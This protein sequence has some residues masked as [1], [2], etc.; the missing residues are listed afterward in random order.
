MASRVG[1]LLITF[2]PGL[3]IGFCVPSCSD[4]T[5]SL[6]AAHCAVC[7]LTNGGGYAEYC[8]VPYGQ[9]L[10]VPRN[11]AQSSE[12]L[13]RA[14]C[15]PE[16]YFTVWHNLIQQTN[17]YGEH[18]FQSTSEPCGLNKR[19]LVHGGSSGIGTTA[20]QLS[21][22]FG[23]EVFATAGS[24]AKCDAIRALGGVPINYA[25]QDFVKV[26]AELTNGAGVDLILDMVGGGYFAQNLGLLARGGRL[27]LIGSLGGPTASEVDLRGMMR[28]RLTGARLYSCCCASPCLC[29]VLCS[30]WVHNSSSVFFCQGSD[31]PA[32]S[33]FMLAT[34]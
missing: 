25:T 34:I 8:A 16:T 18:T 6:T 1:V 19:I 29:G 14:A 24:S 20:I 9:C 27:A 13:L 12:Q 7:A 15:L 23:S 11:L 4:C 30:Q 32:V 21:R 31:G 33:P 2:G 10:P 3:R 28:N 17:S 22:V 5:V 26:V